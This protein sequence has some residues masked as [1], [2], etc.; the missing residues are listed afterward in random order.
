MIRVSSFKKNE[1]LKKKIYFLEDTNSLYEASSATESSQTPQTSERFQTPVDTSSISTEEEPDNLP[2]TSVTYVPDEHNNGTLKKPKKKRISS[3][4]GRGRTPKHLVAVY[5]SQI[6]GDKN[7]IKIRIK[8]SELT[9]IQP[10][11][12]RKPGRRKKHKAYSDTDN[13]DYEKKPK[14]SR[15]NAVTENDVSSTQTGEPTEQSVWGDAARMPDNVLEK[16][17][18]EVCA[19]DG[20]L[21]TLI[22]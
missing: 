13:S 15:S 20:A 12:K 22:R 19:H 6:S 9:T 21:P 4:P 18:A 17:F 2:H 1:K 11:T 5:H 8:K 14:R 10:L 3:G 7:A 16:I